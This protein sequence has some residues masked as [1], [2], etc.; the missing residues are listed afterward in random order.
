MVTEIRCQQMNVMETSKFQQWTMMGGKFGGLKYHRMHY[1]KWGEFLL[2][3]TLLT[4]VDHLSWRDVCPQ[5]AY[6]LSCLWWIA[7]TVLVC[8]SFSHIGEQLEVGICIQQTPINVFC[9]SGLFERFSNNTLSLHH[10]KTN[11][12]GPFRNKTKS[13]R[14]HTAPIT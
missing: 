6:M 7:Y 14:S 2:F 5:F 4:Y 13:T 1:G 11:N 8:A 3:S 9:P 12:Y 10:G